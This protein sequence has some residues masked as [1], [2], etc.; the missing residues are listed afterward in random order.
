MKKHFHLL[1]WC[2]SL[3]LVLQ[4]PAFAQDMSQ[5]AVPTQTNVKTD[6]QLQTQYLGDRLDLLYDNGPIV[7]LPGGGCSG[8]DASIV[9]TALLLT[10]Y[11][12]NANAGANYYMADDFISDGDW[13]ID[14]MM[15]YTYQTS[16]T[17]STIT[18]VYVQIWDGSPMAGGTV[19]WGDL[20]TNVLQRTGLSNIYRALDT[21]P[22]DCARRQQEVVA[23]IGT[24]LPA[25]HYWVQWG[26]TGTSTS[27]PWCPAVTIAGQTTTGDALQY[28][29]GVWAVALNGTFENG[30]PFMVYGTG[31]GTTD[32]SEDF[33]LFTAGQQVACQD[34]TNWTTWS[35]DPCNATEDP[36]ISNAYAY[37]GSNSAMIVQNNDLVKPLGSQTTGT[38]YMSMMVYIPSGK[39]GYFNTVAE[40]YG[41]PQVWGMECYFDVGG[42]GRLLDGATVNFTW[43]ENT[44]QQVMLMVDLDGDLAELFIGTTDPLTS[45]AS[46]QWSQGGT[47]P[48]KLDVN[49]FFGAT[50][51]DEMYFDDY[52]FGQT[53]PPIVPVELS[54]FSAHANNGN[55][56][57][58]WSTATETNNRGFEVQRSNG[59]EFAT[60]GYVD[61]NGT[62]T[63][64]HA[65]SYAD[66]SVATG[67]YSYRLRQVDF[68]GTS[69]YS[70][71]V[72]V[73]V[74]AP[75]VYSLEQNYPNP[76][77]PTTQ[78]NFSLA[79]DSKVTLRIFDVLGQEVA[80][81]LNGNLL[82]GSH[83]VNFDA[84]R[85][86]SGVYLYRID[87]AGADGSN[88]NS[89]KK[90]LLTK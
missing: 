6:L 41:T 43:Q 58:N 76:F 47:I 54:S 84:S 40:F 33:E 60:I 56:L 32:F 10:L 14:S 39:A 70:Q 23:T 87:A 12:W 22:T 67:Q 61:G 20:T 68:D 8:G 80:T 82:A 18:G 75:R 13:S 81:L 11:G 31:A 2:L 24:T 69:S 42:V 59:A 21:A 55:V 28:Q 79:S 86:T 64:A 83:N 65:Y 51:N 37:S 89:V 74:V 29:A 90:M 50:A 66:N 5:D 34:P 73:S 57:L 48:L 72:N 27:G 7:T 25:G 78:I 38:W 15:F 45:I 36:L 85:L 3:I 53:M 62:S 9:E 19:V 17:T 30:A 88:F 63:Q 71:V 26:C 49:D 1:F 44:W 35:Q 52:Y 4:L 77:N 46:W 16:A